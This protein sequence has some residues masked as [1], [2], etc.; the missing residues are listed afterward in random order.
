MAMRAPLQRSAGAGRADEM[1][2]EPHE[3]AVV[4]LRA[5]LEV[6]PQ[7]ALEPELEIKME[8]LLKRDDR[9]RDARYNLCVER[10]TR[11]AVFQSAAA[12]SGAAN[13]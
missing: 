12:I 10:C 7:P 3:D 5:E 9:G 4:H 11:R 13:K 6:E 8:E 1:A 2:A